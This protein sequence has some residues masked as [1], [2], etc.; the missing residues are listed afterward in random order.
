[1]SNFLEFLIEFLKTLFEPLWNILVSIFNSII[2]IFNVMNYVEVFE[3]YSGDF[4]GLAWVLA[5][6]VVILLVAALGGIGFGIYL[7][8][9]KYI[10]VRKTMVSQEELLSELGNLQKE[11]VNLNK[12]KQQIL[13]MKVS[14][15][16]LKPGESNTIDGEDGEGTQEKQNNGDE[17]RFF[18][19][20]RVDERMEN[21]EDPEYNNE[22]T[23]H[24]ICERFRNFACSRMKLFYEIR[25]IRLFLA[26]FASTR[27]IILQGIS[28]TGKTSLPYSF[29]KFIQND[30]QIAAVQ[31]SWRDRSELLGYFNEFTKRYN[32]TEVL[33]KLYEATYKNDVYL[34]I[35][36]EM[37]IARVEYY[38]AEMLSILEMPSRDE[39]IIDLVPTQWDND[40]KHLNAGRFR[41][42]FNVWYVGTANNDDSTFA[43]SD[44]VYDRAI[45]INID[46]K[47]KYFDAPLTDPIKLD[48]RHLERMFNEAKQNNKVSPENLQK[49]NDLDDYVIEHFRLAFGNRIVKQLNDFVPAYVGCGGTELDGLD[50]VLANKIFRKF[51]SLN[52][53]FIRDEI[54]GLID[55]LS[56]LFGQENMQESK[57][58]LRRMKNLF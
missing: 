27:L 4:D 7:L 34:T 18:K 46:S 33:A 14:Q 5:I 55:Y 31:P 48:Y 1:M 30:S 26:A 51:E 29:G 22:L 23:L 25:V 39:W 19:L 40:P 12:E 9:R 42:P 6:L 41:L 38:F 45:P 57:A 56:E 44:K 16:G 50:Y 37:N 15:I 58:Y 49:I 11:V 53:A 43:I 10:R 36:D 35:L 20:T 17:P 2:S 47:G 54:D 32:E 13:S 3:K 8:I 52:L 21:Y 24:E 28:G